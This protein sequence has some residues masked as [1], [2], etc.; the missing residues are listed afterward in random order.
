MA[1]LLT[2]LYFLPGDSFLILTNGQQHV[3]WLQVDL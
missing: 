3:S 2:F 1:F